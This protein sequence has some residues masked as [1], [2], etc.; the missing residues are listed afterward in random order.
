[1]V[2]TLTVPVLWLYPLFGVWILGKLLSD[3]VWT[4]PWLV[5][6]WKL[7]DTFT[8]NSL[9]RELATRLLEKKWTHRVPVCAFDG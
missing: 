4:N 6:T 5:G 2:V 9:D 7:S 3:V 1:M 8:S